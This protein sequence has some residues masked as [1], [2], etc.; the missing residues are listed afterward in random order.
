M[1]FTKK[2][3]ADFFEKEKI[4][5][6]SVIP[7]ASCIVKRVDIMARESFVPRSVI[8]ML[9][10]YYGITVR[11]FSAYAA[12]CDYH[13]YIRELTDRLAEFLHREFPS[14]GLKGYGD[15]S[16]IDERHAALVCG[17]GV[18]GDNRLLINEKYGSYVFIAEMITDIDPELLGADSP[19]EISHCIGC[20]ECK[21]ACATGILTDSSKDC[22]SAIT[23]KKGE[24][25]SSEAALM[26]KNN[27]VWGC[28]KCQSVCPYNQNPK[29][30]PIPF[31]KE[32]LISE[33]TEDVILNMS[34][35]NFSRR[36]FSWRGKRT[37]LRNIEI[38][39]GRE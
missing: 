22:L 13:I 8:V 31:F 37:V 4:E 7:Y 36:A 28:D 2:R 6:F 35:E 25:S 20:G 5:Y 38:L 12:S 18:L 15:H 1:V 3:L 14:A 32:N 16:P 26:R 39:K 17:L 29:E 23:Q 33:L 10:P 9:V 19:I 30:S 34:E 27:T 11:N 24:L 21:R